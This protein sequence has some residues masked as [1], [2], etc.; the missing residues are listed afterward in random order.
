MFASTS[1]GNLDFPINLAPKQRNAVLRALSWCK[2]LADLSDVWYNEARDNANYGTALN[3]EINGKT[4]S[5]YPLLAAR[6]D[7]GL[8][9]RQLSLNHL[10]VW[11]D[12][13][14]VCIVGAR[15]KGHDL[16]T[17][18]VASLILLLGQEEPVLQALPR[19]LSASIYPERFRNARFNRLPFLPAEQEAV[20]VPFRE[21]LAD[22]EWEPLAYLFDLPERDWT[23]LRD[24][25]PW[26]DEPEAALGMAYWLSEDHE[27][28]AEDHLWVL[29]IVQ[30]HAV[31]D[32]EAV[33]RSYLYCPHE[34]VRRHVLSHY[35]PEDSS[36]AWMFLEPRFELEEDERNLVLIHEILQTYPELESFLLNRSLRLVENGED[37]SLY[38]TALAWLSHRTDMD[39][40]LMELLP[41]LEPHELGPYLHQVQTYGAWFEDFGTD[42]LS[43][44]FEGIHRGVVDC[45]AR[46][47]SFNP[48]N[49]WL[50]LMENGSGNMKVIIMRH[51]GR[52]S[53]DEVYRMLERCWKSRW[54]FVVNATHRLVAKEYP[55]YP[56]RAEMEAYGYTSVNYWTRR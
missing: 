46:N 1:F 2:E 5:I 18:L 30:Q 13:E 22:A 23:I 26:H 25:F 21:H 36:E 16:H 12:G 49:L 29:N 55:D 54:R 53:L 19:T 17:D 4:L 39:E 42:C 41:S 6:L 27:R 32:F 14:K 9:T 50:P 52:L 10:P 43:L 56:K 7:A 40:W 33:L 35:R 3:R 8:Y 31:D 51:F 15:G 38:R 48:F 45:S 37:S 11:L 47:P 28:P 34:E 24:R 20:F 44:P